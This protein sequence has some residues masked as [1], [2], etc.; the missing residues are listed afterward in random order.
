MLLFPQKNEAESDISGRQFYVISLRSQVKE[1][2]CAQFRLAGFDAAKGIEQ[3]L[4]QLEKLSIPINASGVVVDIG[5]STEV[6]AISHALQINIP[7]E[8]WCCVV[9]DS[10]SIALSQSFMRNDIHYFN[11]TAQQDAIIQA[12]VLGAGV[13]ARRQPVSISIL[14]CKGGVGSTSISYQLASEISRIKQIPTLLI[15]GSHGSRDL[16]LHAGKKLQQEITTA[17]KHFDLMIAQSDSLPDLSQDIYSA[18]NFVLFEDA[19]NTADKEHMRHLAEHALCLV[20]V[21]DRSMASIRVARNMIESVEL[22]RRTNNLTR[23]LLISLNDTR[24]VSINSISDEDV[25]SLLGK[26]IDIFF[27][28][29]KLTNRKSSTFRSPQTPLQT[30][31]TYVLGGAVRPKSRWLTQRLFSSKK[32]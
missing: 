20:L 21:I 16:D 15:Q 1:Q 28:Y 23:R 7:L 14:G 4:M 26:P 9:G 12:A 17:Q 24:P 30:L 3:N 31:T 27:P 11:I 29:S 5:S 32:E 22:L 25:Q 19:I 18:Y 2:L 10:D 8:V 13:K 6:D